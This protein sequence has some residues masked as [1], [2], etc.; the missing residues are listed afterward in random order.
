M[1]EWTA[2][3]FWKDTSVAAQDD[4][5]TV[6]LDSRPVRTPA[7]AQLTLPTRQLAEMV[8]AEWDAQED[9]I[10]P[11][12]MPTTRGANVAIDRIENA[13]EEVVS[14]LA[15]YGDADLVCYRAAYPQALV[16]R[17]DAQWNPLLDWAAETFGARLETR[18]GVMHSGQSEESLSTLKQQIDQFTAF[19]LAAF[20]DLV[21]LS[22][23]VIIALAATR[24]FQPIE[25]LWAAS[26]L[27]EI[28]QQEQWGEDDE[29]SQ[30]AEIK[31]QSFLHA[32]S[33][34]QAVQK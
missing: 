9:K 13:R 20:H 4:G 28:F 15:D 34:F 33:F 12:S 2:K 23:S 8:A 32:H 6:L 5:F 10:D 25:Q 24:N 19:E 22:G 18:V 14:M 7:K 26:R 30:E 11:Q 17:Q 1:S 27:D 31:R 21:T 16:D 3:R 29:A